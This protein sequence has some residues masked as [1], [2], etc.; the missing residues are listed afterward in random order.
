M[1]DDLS[2]KNTSE[3]DVFSIF[4]KDGISFPANRKL[5]F[6]QK[7]KDDLFAKNTPKDGISGITD[8]HPRKDDIDILD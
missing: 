6:C 2:Q 8:I 3:Y 1:K 7:S 5:L 4:G